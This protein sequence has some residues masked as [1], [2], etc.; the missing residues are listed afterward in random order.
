MASRNDILRM[1][2]TGLT[3]GRVAAQLKIPV[4]AVLKVAPEETPKP[5]PKKKKA[6]PPPPKAAEPPAE[7]AAPTKRKGPPK[8]VSRKTPEY[9]AE[10]VKQGKVPKVG[11]NPKGADPEKRKATQ[12][13]RGNPGSGLK[14][15]PKA[16]HE[17][18]TESFRRYWREKTDDSDKDAVWTGL[19]MRARIG[20]DRAIKLMVDL[21]GESLEAAAKEKLQKDEGCRVVFMLPAKE[22]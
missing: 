4:E 5:K 13:K 3:P 20:D 22:S 18:I 16:R 7:P 12:F 17:T 9:I 19:L 15:N 8:G 1:L 14:K 10:C 21:N 11:G 2:A 6:P